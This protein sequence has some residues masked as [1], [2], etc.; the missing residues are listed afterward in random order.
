VRVGYLGLDRLILLEANLRLLR[1]YNL[2]C[3]TN[4]YDR[5]RILTA[6]TIGGLAYVHR[7]AKLC[8]NIDR[9]DKSLRELIDFES[10]VFD[11]V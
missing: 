1:C 2:Y 4:D 5:G 3:L 11:F 10:L 7:M 6:I 8:I 9:L